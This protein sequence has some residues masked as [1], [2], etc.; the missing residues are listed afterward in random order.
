M[1]LLGR[2]RWTA[3]PAYLGWLGPLLEQNLRTLDEMLTRSLSHDTPL[4]AEALPQVEEVRGAVLFLERPDLQEACQRILERLNHSTQ[5]E[6]KAATE[7]L[8]DLALLEDALSEMYQ[9]SRLLEGTAA[10]AFAAACEEQLRLIEDQWDVQVPL[11]DWEGME[12]SLGVLQQLTDAWK[13]TG[14]DH[15]AQGL[16]RIHNRVEQALVQ[17]PKNRPEAQAVFLSIAEGLVAVHDEF[18]IELSSPT[19]VA[20]A[21]AALTAQHTLATL[22]GLMTEEIDATR[23]RFLD[24]LGKPELLT[25]L[26]PGMERTAAAFALLEQPA[27]AREAWALAERFQKE[28]A[29]SDMASS[30]ALLEAFSQGLLMRLPHV[31][32]VQAEPAPAPLASTP[33]SANLDGLLDTFK[34][35]APTMKA[36]ISNSRS[37]DALELRKGF[38][39]AATALLEEG[40]SSAQAL[41]QGCGGLLSQMLESMEAPGLHQKAAVLQGFRSLATYLNAP[42]SPSRALETSMQEAL[43]RVEKAVQIQPLT[44]PMAVLKSLDPT[45]ASRDWPV[46]STQAEEALWDFLA[47]HWDTL[48]RV[49]DPDFWMAI[50]LLETAL[51]LIGAETQA[52]VLA[53]ARK[54]Q[55]LDFLASRVLEDLLAQYNRKRSVE[56]AEHLVRRLE[57]NLRAARLALTTNDDTTLRHL[58]AHH[59]DLLQ[60][61]GSMP[62]P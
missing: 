56:T 46:L 7:V 15:S 32:A 47:R 24:A 36:W 8:T 50:A 3:Q 2:A 21:T 18:K 38:R 42:L 30:I 25:D 62:S 26:V 29:S 11:L 20:E 6:E 14:M 39:Q 4:P 51:R 60:E 13:A 34:G 1:T 54:E 43:D 19:S 53:N 59:H 41:A 58:L 55:A 28:P 37:Q 12:Q 16:Q 40:S 61:F 48:K 9:G 45:H 27:A 49:E 33:P 35:L 52:R 31:N 44:T 23:H 5:L 10:F 17:P 22:S 57:E